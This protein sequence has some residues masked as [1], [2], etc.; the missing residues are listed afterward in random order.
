MVSSMITSAQTD[1]SGEAAWEDI[2][3]VLSHPR[4]ANCHVGDDHTPRWS[5]PSYEAAYGF[6]PGGWMYHGMNVSGDISRIGNSTLPCSTC[7][8]EEN[9]NVA[10]APPGAHAWALAPV[11]MEWFG[12]ASSEVCIRLK[13]PETNGN[14]TIEEV[15]DHID[16]DELVH[17]GWAP[18]PGREPAPFDRK[19]TAEL[20]RQ[21]GLD[22]APCPAGSFDLKAYLNSRMEGQ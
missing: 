8:Q 6:E 5:G 11:E 9:A 21:W 13:S 22:G 17:W 15:A 3:Q 2:F 1:N 10:H 4:C 14:R 12:K 19:T 7:H 20:I 18:G 16:N